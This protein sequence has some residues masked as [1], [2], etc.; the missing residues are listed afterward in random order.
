M[1]KMTKGEMTRERILTSAKE[2]FYEQ[3]YDETTIQQIADHSGTTLGSMTY[4]F[5]TKAKFVERI[6]E[7]YFSKIYV[8]SKNFIYI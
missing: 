4:H 7:D 5:A 8:L 3:G 6:F 2:L 1:R